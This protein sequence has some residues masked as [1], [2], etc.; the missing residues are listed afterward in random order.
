[1]QQIF[2]FQAVYKETKL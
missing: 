2:V 1:M